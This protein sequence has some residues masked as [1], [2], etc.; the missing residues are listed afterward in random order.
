M[1]PNLLAGHTLLWEGA[2]HDDGGQKVRSGYYSTKGGQGRGKCSCG[3]LSE[4]L[5]SANQRKQWHR[6]HKARIRAERR[7]A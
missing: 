6:D 7:Q 5:D 2:A 1:R 3:D 4:V